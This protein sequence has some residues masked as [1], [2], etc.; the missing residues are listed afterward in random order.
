MHGL[1][2][3]NWIAQDFCDQTFLLVVLGGGGGNCSVCC[4]VVTIARAI[5]DAFWDG[6]QL[7]EGLTDSAELEAAFHNTKTIFAGLD[8]AHE[9][10]IALEAAVATH[11]TNIRNQLTTHDTD[12]KALFGDIQ[13]TLDNEIE[14]TQVHLTI[15]EVKE[16]KEYLVVATEAGQPVEV[17]FTSVQVSSGQQVDFVESISS[18]NVTSLAPG[19]Y[20]L[21]L[22]TP[23]SITDIIAV[24]V[25]HPDEV[26]HFG[27]AVF[28]RIGDNNLR[29]D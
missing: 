13:E 11:D 17:E 23:P 22:T 28:H 4:L 2:L 9:D 12:I 25:L 24:T 6:V 27:H 5:G 29:Q 8:H 3:A 26:D 19:T 16:K 20:L 7:C 15:V 1:R 10:L 21:T 14:K 18:T